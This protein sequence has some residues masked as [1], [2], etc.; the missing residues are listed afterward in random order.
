[1]DA[2]LVVSTVW[3]NGSTVVAARG[4]LDIA[5]KPLL[6]A[7]VDDALHTRDGPLIID[8]SEVSFI[9]AQGLSALVVSRRYATELNRS[10]TLAGTPA[11]VRRLL[12]LT[13]LEDGF[14]MMASPDM[15]DPVDA[16]APLTQTR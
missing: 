7:Q 2:A 11:L 4:E 1:M 3:M 5:G 16:H 8:L 13:G 10:L 9:D 6:C 12:Q 14:A 15:A